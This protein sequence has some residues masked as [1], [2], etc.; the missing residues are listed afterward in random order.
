MSELPY[1]YL[2]LSVMVL[3]ASV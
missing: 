3:N 1:S 2:W